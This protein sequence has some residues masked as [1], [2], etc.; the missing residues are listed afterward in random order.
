MSE[1]KKYILDKWTLFR[2]WYRSITYVNMSIS[3]PRYYGVGFANGIIPALRKLYADRPEEIKDALQKYGESYYL[4]EPSTGAAVTAVVLRMEEERANGADISRDSINAFKTGV[5]GGLTGFGDTI[6]SSTLRPLAMAIFTPMAIAGNVMGPLGFL[7]FK[8]TARYA[9]GALWY[10]SCLKLG[11]AA[12]GSMLDKGSGLLKM[13]VDGTAIL[14]MFVMG[15]MT[16]KY[17]T[18]KVALQVT[19]SETTASLQ[20]FLD[21]ALPG[22]IPIGTVFLMYWLMGS[23][24][25]SVIKVILIFLVISIVGSLIGLF[26]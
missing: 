4:A 2:C 7:L 19:V 9:N 17:V 16:S 8:G 13:L 23:K 5:M 11:K 10:L 12:L 22:I 15:A 1:K 26:A 14:S 24:K 25:M 6:F 20:S 3:Y 18:A 21:S